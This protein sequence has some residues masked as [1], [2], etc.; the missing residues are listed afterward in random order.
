MCMDGWINRIQSVKNTQDVRGFILKGMA[1]S[2]V[3][4]PF[5]HGFPIGRKIP[6]E[7]TK[8]HVNISNCSCSKAFPFAY[9]CLDIGLNWRASNHWVSL[10][11]LTKFP[12]SSGHPFWKRS[13]SQVFLR[14]STLRSNYSIY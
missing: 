2:F 7:Q 12:Q 5:F 8:K 11:K 6:I 1:E 9:V 10:S 4:S 3:H 14:L 13:K